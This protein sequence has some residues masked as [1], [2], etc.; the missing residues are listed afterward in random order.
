MPPCYQD[1]TNQ[2]LPCYQDLTNQMLP[3]YQDLT[4]Q[5]PPCYQDLTN[6]MP[7][8]YQD[9]REPITFHCAPDGLALP[10]TALQTIPALPEV[11]QHW[12]AKVLFRWSR[13]NQPELDHSKV[14][15]LMRQQG[16]GNSSSQLQKQLEEQHAETWIEQQI[17][18]LSEYQGVAQA[19]SS[20]LIS[21]VPPGD[22]P[23]MPAVPKYRWLMQVYAQDV[24][25]WLEEVKA[26]ITSLFGQAYLVDC[27]SRW[28][29]DRTVTAQGLEGP[30]FYSGLL[31]H[32]ANWLSEEVLGRKLVEYTSPR[33]YTRELIGI[34]YL[35]SQNNA[36]MQDYKCFAAGRSAAQWPDSNCVC[37]SLFVKLCKEY[38]GPR[39]IDGVRH[40]RWSLVTRANLHIQQVILNN[41]AVMEGTTIQLPVVNSATIATWYCKRERR[42]DTQVLEQ[43]ISAPNPAT[44]SPESLPPAVERKGKPCMPPTS[45]LCLQLWSHHSRLQHKLCS[46]HPILLCLHPDLSCLH[47][48]HLCLQPNLSCLHPDLLC[49]QPDLS[50]LHPDLLCLQPDIFCLLPDLLCLQPDLSCL[51]PDLLCLQPDLSCLHPDLLCLQPDLSCLHPDLLCLQPDILCLLPD[52]SCLH[53]D[54][55]CLQPNLSCLHPDLLCLQPDLS[56]LLPDLFCLQPTLLC[57]LHNQRFL[58]DLQEPCLTPPSSTIKRKSKLAKRKGLTHERPSPANS[59]RRS[60]TLPPTS[61]ILVIGTVRPQST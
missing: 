56:C 21:P 37:E 31:R 44:V 49:L 22:L 48:I 27:L 19:V 30:H 36:V 15:R 20:G 33:K 17:Q 13:N 9:L 16:L 52:L 42:Q 29:E 38:R 6:Q 26:S 55:L 43:G 41:A 45:H 4:N 11:D 51:H 25:S 57:Q 34:Q 61:S 2:M 39:R 8:C 1:L 28:N 53:P 35:Y 60:G 50:C 24:L 18:F 3:C 47:P 54:L 12:I 59:A 10:S 40:E 23:A 5:M 32:V 58:S 7:R 14:V 46:L